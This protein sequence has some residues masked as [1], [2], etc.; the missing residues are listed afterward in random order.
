MSW[1][2]VRKNTKGKNSQSERERKRQQKMNYFCRIFGKSSNAIWVFVSITIQQRQGSDWHLSEK[3]VPQNLNVD[4]LSLFHLDIECR[5]MLCIYEITSKFASLPLTKVATTFNRVKNYVFF[6]EKRRQ[7]MEIRAKT[8]EK[9][10]KMSSIKLNRKQKNKMEKR[11]IDLWYSP[12]RNCNY[13][14]IVYLRT[15]FSVANVPLK[16]LFIF[17]MHQKLKR[18]QNS[19]FSFICANLN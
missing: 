5:P 3:D 9:F 8:N 6:V 4:A 16:F 15:P 13:L 11:E 12:V 17:Y 14:A 1:G 19:V 2:F 18:I 7:K 10:M